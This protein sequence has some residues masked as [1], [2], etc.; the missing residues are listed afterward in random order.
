MRLDEL[1]L[2]ACQRATV[3]RLD[4][5]HTVAEAPLDLLQDLEPVLLGRF[6]RRTAVPSYVTNLLVCFPHRLQDWVCAVLHELQFC[7]QPFP[8]LLN[9]AHDG[10]VHGVS[11][12]DDGRGLWP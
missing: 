5:K 6:K 2:D 10:A 11:F 12:H 3:R 1:V 4:F 8:R 9:L 7:V